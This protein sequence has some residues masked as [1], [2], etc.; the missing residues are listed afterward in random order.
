MTW[1]F[2][3]FGVVFFVATILNGII[4]VYSIRHREV[5]G[6]FAFSLMM[7]SMS[8]W[9]LFLA[10]EY[11]VV[12]IED[13]ILFSKL[14]YLGISTIGLTWFLFAY[15]YSRGRNLPGKNYLWLLIFP[16]ILLGLTFTNEAHGLL[17]PEIKPV[18][19]TPGADL[20]YEHGPAFWASVA[21]NYIFL[22]LG[23]VI[24]IRTALNAKEIYRWQMIGLVA[25]VILPWVGNLIS[26]AGLSPVPGLDLGPIAFVL[27]G[28]IIAWSIFFLRLLDLL[29]V[30]YDQV[31]ANLTDGV[32]VLDVHHRIA[33]ANPKAREMLKVEKAHIIGR[34]VMEVL[35]PWP[36][37]A[38]ALRGFDLGEIE[39]EAGDENISDLDIR[40][41]ALLD[42]NRV[43]VGRIAIFRDISQPKK[44]E[45]V[46]ADL[47]QSIVNDL[48]NPLTSM[49]INLEMLRR[50]STTL[51]PKSQIETLDLSQTILQQT[52]E[53]IESI[54]DI[55]RLQSGEIP[56]ARKATSLKILADE[57]FRNISGLASKKRILLQSDIPE[58]MQPLMLD[59]GLMRRVLQN[60]LGNSIKQSQEGRIVRLNARYDKNGVLVLSVIDS[61]ET[62]EIPFSGEL[63]KKSTKGQANNSLSWAFCR[64]AIEAHGGDIWLD[65]SYENGT[66]ISLSLPG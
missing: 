39:V 65:E 14:Q 44:L 61:A 46:R 35:Q 66:K 57:A 23:A 59:P 29:P 33:D 53:Q 51:L 26:I 54:L 56:L 49:S 32:L 4:L 21:Y 25:S 52:L 3:S 41:T 8:A 40:V 60:L 7:A 20:V 6:A 2:S 64:L 9:A 28:I 62:T 36:G 24:I 12:G 10:L 58:G 5:R 50:Q 38:E 22:A 45:R 42:N 15:G 34:N 1:Q 48:R 19:P 63:F 31:V 17:W 27:S 18:S 37:L 43:R 13:K 30:A 55:Y 16:I 47:T 11:S